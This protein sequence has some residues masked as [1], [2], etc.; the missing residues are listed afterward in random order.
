MEAPAAPTPSATARSSQPERRGRK[1][2]SPHIF[3]GVSLQQ[4]RRLFHAAGDQHA[5][6]RAELVWGQADAAKL[7]RALIGSRTQRR[8]SRAEAP[9]GA[10]GHK[11]LRAFGHLRINEGALSGAKEDNMADGETEA[12][13]VLQG[14]AESQGEMATADGPTESERLQA[15]PK[16]GLWGGAGSL[17]QG[18]ERN[19]ERYL[20]RILH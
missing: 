7:A 4:L 10:L 15:T 9:G 18:G 16:G 19:C 14:A 12:G 5:E 13:T 17:R 20:H 11:W 1:S 8:R 2:G 6:R 3:Q